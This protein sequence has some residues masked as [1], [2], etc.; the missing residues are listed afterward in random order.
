MRA[1][2]FRIV[3]DGIAGEVVQDAWIAVIR[4]LP[5]FEGRSSLEVLDAGALCASQPCY[6]AAV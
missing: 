6:P 3:G 2:A 4:S 5:K 1:L